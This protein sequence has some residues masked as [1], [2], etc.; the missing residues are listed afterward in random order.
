VAPWAGLHEGGRAPRALAV[1]AAMAAWALTWWVLRGTVWLAAG[2]AATAGGAPGAPV[3][4]PKQHWISRFYKTNTT[5][6]CC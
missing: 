6:H 1:L 2:A 5:G 3:E 4:P